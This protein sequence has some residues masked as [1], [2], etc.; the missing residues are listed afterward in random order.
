M[1]STSH[2][3][4]LEKHHSST[5]VYIFTPTG[6]WPFFKAQIL[7]QRIFFPFQLSRQ[8]WGDADLPFDLTGNRRN[9]VRGKCRSSETEHTS[10]SVST[11][12]RSD[13]GSHPRGRAQGRAG[14]A[15]GDTACRQVDGGGKKSSKLLPPPS[16]CHVEEHQD[17]PHSWEFKISQF[18][19]AEH[20]YFTKLFK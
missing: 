11:R 12:K 6:L 10:A 15:V 13:C 14:A 8:R 1:W 19:C 9:Y 7:P 5:N 20:S 4:V 16:C 2:Q 18:K 3:C 17:S